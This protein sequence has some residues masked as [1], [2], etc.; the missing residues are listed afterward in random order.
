MDH[1]HQPLGPVEGILHAA[2]RAGRQKGDDEGPDTH[3]RV[4]VPDRGD[5]AKV[6]MAIRSEQCPGPVI[7][8]VLKRTGIGSLAGT[9]F[10]VGRNRS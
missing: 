8:G 4:A 7:G 3:R 6:I 5:V 9:P 1:R 10:F 2:V